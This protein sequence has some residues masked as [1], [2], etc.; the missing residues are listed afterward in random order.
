MDPQQARA[1]LNKRAE[2]LDRARKRAEDKDTAERQAE[3]GMKKLWKAVKNWNALKRCFYSPQTSS[4]RNTTNMEHLSPRIHVFV[5]ICI[6]WS[7]PCLWRWVFLG[8]G[9]AKTKPI[10][11]W[12][13]IQIWHFC[14]ICSSHLSDM[15]S[16]LITWPSRAVLQQNMPLVFSS[17]IKTAGSW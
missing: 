4:S 8:A 9:E 5:A 15:V 17:Y 12:P 1:R 16:F 10:C 2:R 7:M 11:S 6:S 14:W 13:C 3:E